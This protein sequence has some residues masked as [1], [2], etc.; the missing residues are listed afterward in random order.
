L[1]DKIYKAGTTPFYLVILDSTA[2]I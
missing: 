2:Q 1:T